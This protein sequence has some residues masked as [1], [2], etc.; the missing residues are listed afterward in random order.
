[1]QQLK[2]SRLVSVYSSDPERAKFIAGKFAAEKSYNNYDEFL[3]SDF[4]ALYISSIN[5]NHY[6]QVIKGA[7]A[8]KHILCEKPLAL[9]SEQARLMIK[10]CEE[11]NV[12][13]SINYLHRFHPLVSKAKELIKK[14]LLGKVVSISANFNINFAPGNN[15]RFKKELSGGGA[16]RDIGTHM[17]DL[18]RYLGGEIDEVKGFMDNV[19]Y[20]SEVEDFAAGLVKFSN[21]S[22][23]SFNVT[24]NTPKAFNRIE[25]LG[26]KGCLSIENLIGKK[27]ESS[28]LVINLDGEA[29]KSFRRRANKQLYLLRSVQKSFLNNEI[30]LITG[31][32]GLIN[33]QLMEEFERKCL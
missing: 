21:G 17:L 8:G 12:L 33:L 16:L 22:Y 4:D 2:K 9:S 31:N 24:Y 3:N 20:K 25:V 14:F 13:L 23:G 27:F 6:E 29:K 10:S 15:Y 28:K 5:S 26:Y 11:N 1:M 32:D 30:P 18:L 19:V 7:L